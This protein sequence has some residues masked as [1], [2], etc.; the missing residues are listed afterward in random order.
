[1]TGC[2]RAA[3]SLS[4]IN[5]LLIAFGVVHVF[6]CRIKISCRRILA[7]VNIEVCIEENSI[8]FLKS[9]PPGLIRALNSDTIGVQSRRE[10]RAKKKRE[11]D[12]VIVSAT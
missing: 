8:E 7:D 4:F 10:Q 6:A 9:F 3:V 2:L 11:N 12:T 5:H 1:M